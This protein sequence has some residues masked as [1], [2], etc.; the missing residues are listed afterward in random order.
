M[1]TRLKCMPMAYRIL[2]LLT[3]SFLFSS[4]VFADHL[5]NRHHGQASVLSKPL[6]STYLGVGLGFGGDEVGRFTD[7]YRYTE[8]IHSGGGLLLEGGLNLAVDPLTNLRLSGGYQIDGTSRG[9]GSST[10]DRLRFDLSLLR[11]I[12]I[13]EFGAGVTA[14]TSVGYRCDIDTI[15][16]GDVDFNHA[17]GFTMEYAVRAGVSAWAGGRGVRLGVRF[18][19]I[20]YTPRLANAEML[21]GNSLTGFVGVIF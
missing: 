1:T 18:T 14:H 5:R 10:F 11:S 12:G 6:L 13:H 20:E 19:G 7:G 15:C 21:D 2:C 3:L 16:A 4:S 17:I 8:T 9:N